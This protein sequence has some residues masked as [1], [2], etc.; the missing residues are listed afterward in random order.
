[1]RIGILGGSFNPPHDG[2]VAAAKAVLRARLVDEVWVMPCWRQAGKKLAPFR[3]RMEMA[4]IAFGGIR[5]VR[6]SDFEEKYNR[7]GKTIETIRALKRSYPRTAF[8]WIIGSDLLNSLNS[9]DEAA[10]LKKSLDFVVVKRGKMPAKKLAAN[11]VVLDAKTP[12]VSSTEIRRKLAKAGR[13][14]RVRGVSA[15]VLS[16]WLGFANGKRAS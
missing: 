5:G 4:R 9:W 8:S 14:A 13:G 16:R 6:V 12:D 2:H 15:G 7:T 3:T 11:F 1:M 10:A